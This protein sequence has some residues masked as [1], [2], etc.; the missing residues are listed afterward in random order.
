M[1]QMDNI[2]RFIFQHLDIRGEIVHLNDTLKQILKPHNYPK[3]IQKLLSEAVLCSV[4]ITATIKF[5]GQVTVQFQSEDA[6]KLLLVKCNHQFEVRALAQY[7]E[8]ASYVDVLKNGKLAVT[9]E[10]DDKVRPYQSIVPIKSSITDS[11]KNYFNQSEQLASEFI[12]AFNGERGVGLL[13]Q[14]LPRQVETEDTRASSWEEILMLTNTL[15]HDELFTL[16][17]ETILHRLFNEHSLKLF[18]PQAVTFCC[19]CNRSR[20]LEMV[21][22]MGKED[23]YNLLGT[24]KMIEVTCE[25]CQQ[26]FSFE[27]DDIRFLFESQ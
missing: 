15:H 19:T 22:T 10:T 7:D 1:Y 6:I 16:D 23:A 5:K 9:I 14:Q 17:N 2:Q 21:R 8:H 24:Y 25:F 11:L 13:L 27:K 26:S 4:L 18:N 20:M 3:E 12:L